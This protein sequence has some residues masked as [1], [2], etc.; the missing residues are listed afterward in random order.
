M[1]GLNGSDSRDVLHSEE[2]TECILSRD[3]AARLK[4]SLHSMACRGLAEG[5][6]CANL[7]EARATVEELMSEL[8]G[9]SS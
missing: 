3:A 8:D 5:G 9:N 4:E 1:S 6:I 2:M 7:D